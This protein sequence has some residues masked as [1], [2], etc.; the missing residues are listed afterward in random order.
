MDSNSFRDIMG[1]F[2]TGVTVVTTCVDGLYHGFTA[3]AVCSVALDPP[4]LLV[5][6]DK[7][8]VAHGQL[9]RAESF[10]VS[11]LSAEQETVSNLFASRSEPEAGGMRD[12]PFRVG[13]TG[14]PL[15]DGAL[16]WLECRS[17]SQA[18]GGDHTIFFGEAVD[19]GSDAEQDPLL[20]F[21]GGYRFVS[22]VG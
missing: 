21:R 16:A 1:T 19:G 3:N 15:L 7:G 12:L 2:A 5:C 4:L 22:P 18:E 11:I 20:F 17:H 13:E 8:G 9:T 6:A 14:A 10:G